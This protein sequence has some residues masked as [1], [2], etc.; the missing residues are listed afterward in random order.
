MYCY[1]CAA[2]LVESAVICPKC[3]APTPNYKSS[4][5]DHFKPTTGLLLGGAMIPFV[6]WGIGH[7]SPDEEASRSRDRNAGPSQLHVLLLDRF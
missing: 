6:G 3:R 7:L 1:T 2:E 4:Q 5:Q